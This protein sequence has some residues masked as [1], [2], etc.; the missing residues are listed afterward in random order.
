MFGQVALAVGVVIV[1]YIYKAL[2]PPPPKICGTPDGPPVTSPRIKLR[3]GRHLSYREAG[4]A[5]EEAAYKIIVIHGFASSKDQSLPV[6]QELAEELKLYFLYFDRAGYGESDPNPKR[7]VKSEAFDIQELADALQLGSKFYVIGISMGG[8]PA[9][10]CI[11]YIPQRLAG[12]ALV[13]PFVHYWWTGFPSD[14]YKKAFRKLPAVSDQWTFRVAHYAP[15]LLY[16]WMTQNLFTSL[17]FMSG[18]PS[19]FSQKDL[20]ILVKTPTVPQVDQEKIRQQGV[21][22]S[23]HRDIMAGYAS[24]EFSPLDLKNPFPDDNGSVHI[25]QGYED[26]MIP[27]EINRYISEKLPWIKYHEV[28]DGGHMFLCEPS[29]CESIIRALV[30]G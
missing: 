22:E 10:S 2:K 25:W 16:W 28:P 27:F 4:V 26:K 1:R 20:E 13:A 14:L 8:Y 21:H 15:W 19:V 23:L 12:V 30:L 3:D 24:W 9:W 5:K 18:G 6:S 29:V 7:S 11:K 17:S